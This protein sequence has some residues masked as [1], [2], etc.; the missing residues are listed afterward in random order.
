MRPPCVWFTV[1]R[2]IVVIA[3]AGGCFAAFRVH[4]ALG[5]LFASVSCLSLIHIY[6]TID[7]SQAGGR[8]M[9]SR[10]IVQTF[11]TSVLVAATILVARPSSTG[12]RLV[13]YKLVRVVVSW[14]AVLCDRGSPSPRPSVRHLE[15]CP[16]VSRTA[17]SGDPRRTK[18]LANWAAHCCLLLRYRS[19]P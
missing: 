9:R 11:V 7:R 18:Q 6:G 15:T 17:G 13:L 5:S 16:P 8:P 10:E 2:V 4:P 1:R 12:E 19:I 14:P 3:A